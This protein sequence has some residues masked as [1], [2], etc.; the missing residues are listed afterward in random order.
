MCLT[1]GK[2]MNNIGARGQTGIDGKNASNSS[3]FPLSTHF[4]MLLCSAFCEKVELFPHALDQ[5]CD[6]LW[7]QNAL[8]VSR[9]SRNPKRPCTH[10][11]CDGYSFSMG[12]SVRSLERL[13]TDHLR[14][15]S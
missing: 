14:W 12:T 2:N 5:L 15:N 4:V 7:Q 8:A 6:L 13:M 1:Y 10:H 3:P 11:L 9:P